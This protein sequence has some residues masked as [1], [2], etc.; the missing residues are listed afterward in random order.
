[1]E[2]KICLITG[3]TSGIGK[4]IA[5][6]LAQK[7][8]QIGI[9]A[10]NYSKA[11]KTR[12][13]IIK[14]T[15]N[16]NIRIFIADFASLDQVR[17][18]AAEINRS[19]EKID[20]LVNNAGVLL[21]DKR[22]VSI[23]GNELTLTTNHLSPFLLASLIF[24]KL[25][26]SNEARIINTSSVAHKFAR[27]DF[28]DINLKKKY[29]PFKAY[30]NSK[31][32]N[33]MFTIELAKRLHKYPNITT[34][35]YHPGIVASNFSKE[36]GGPLSFIYKIATPFISNNN[37]GAET[38]IFLATDPKAAKTNGKYLVKRKAVSPYKKYLSEGN[39]LKL[40]EISVEMTNTKFL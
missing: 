39:C 2:N 21:S 17:N 24:E 33:L 27:V 10:R 15:G 35:A 5:T 26:K 36:S 38:G 25:I 14:K 40:W 18:V 6:E 11:E 31:L 22:E 9:V 28:E 7:G 29:S 8:F 1:M 12:D 32:Y 37:Q 23:E 20:V 34:N 13:Q 16:K 19:Y 4:V 30:S 3:A